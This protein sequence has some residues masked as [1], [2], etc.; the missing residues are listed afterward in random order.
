VTHPCDESTARY[1]ANVEAASAVTGF[2]RP[3]RGGQTRR[4][5]SSGSK[6]SVVSTAGMCADFCSSDGPLNPPKRPGRWVCEIEKERRVSSESGDWASWTNGSGCAAPA[7]GE[8]VGET[9]FEVMDGGSGR[10]DE[11]LP[12][13]EERPE[14]CGEGRPLASAAGWWPSPRPASSSRRSSLRSETDSS[15]PDRTGGAACSVETLEIEANRLDLNV[16]LDKI[17]AAPALGDGAR[18]AAAE[19]VVEIERARCRATPDGDDARRTPRCEASS[20]WLRGDLE[21]EGL[22]TSEAE[23]TVTGGAGAWNWLEEEALAWPAVL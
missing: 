23:A 7:G 17:G 19:V 6:L 22:G 3:A 8:S 21:I 14:A 5:P 4:W 2:R 9:G 13:R 10:G 11:M 20:F 1:S 15:T 12:G 18:D 16:E